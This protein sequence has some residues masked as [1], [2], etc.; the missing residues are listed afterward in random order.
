MSANDPEFDEERK[1]LFERLEEEIESFSTD[2]GV[3][4]EELSRMIEEG[5]RSLEKE[6]SISGDEAR[7]VI[8][9]LFQKWQADRKSGKR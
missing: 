3:G 5:Y 9:A 6:G 2:G 7:Q 1:R 4:P 8:D